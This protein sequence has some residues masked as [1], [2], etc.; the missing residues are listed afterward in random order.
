[1]A[2]IE[3]VSIQY[4]YIDIPEINEISNKIDV[5][6]TETKPSSIPEAVNG[7]YT[8]E[9]IKKGTYILFNDPIY[10]YKKIEGTI[11][12]DDSC[13]MNDLAYRNG[14]YSIENIK[15][16]TNVIA[17]RCECSF[18][19]LPKI[20]CFQAINDIEAG[21]ELSRVYGAKYWEE[22]N[23]WLKYPKSEWRKTHLDE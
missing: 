17:V 23:F 19:D 22:Y 20:L 4:G 9:D 8:L 11:V 18:L 5:I 21:A 10:I 7:L 6:K 16:Y 1:M 14:C 15:K 3:T 2:N 12:S 13:N